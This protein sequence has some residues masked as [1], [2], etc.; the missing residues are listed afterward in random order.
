MGGIYFYNDWHAETPWGS[1]RPDYGRK[2]VRQFIRDNALMWLEEY[3]VDG[4]RFDMTLYI[5][6]VRASDDPGGDLPDGWS[7][8]QWINRE[9][10]QRY[11][12]RIT[13]AEDLQNDDRI[14]KPV[15]QA[16]GGFTAQWAARFVHPVRAAVITPSD[17]QRSLDSVRGA[18]EGRYNGD[19]FQRVIYSESHDEVA[20]GKARVASEIDPHDPDSWFAQKRTTLA[21]ALVLTAPGIPML[22]QGQEFLEDGW[23]QDSVPSGLAQVGGVQRPGADVSGLDSSSPQPVGLDARSFG[24]RTEHLPSESGR[25][26]DC[27]SSLAPTA[28]PAMTWWSS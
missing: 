28:A 12:G 27:L 6:N 20:N 16:G 11:P 22:F 19:P 9:V 25:Q 8:V 15:D 24:I 5:H 3:H 21:A 13:I 23:F 10:R 4:L 14:T 18:I 7:L 2:E 17:E 1:T 26:R